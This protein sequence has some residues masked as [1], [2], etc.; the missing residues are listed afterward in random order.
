MRITTPMD[1]NS[2]RILSYNEIVTCTTDLLSDAFGI[3]Q[4]LNALLPDLKME[5]AEN[6]IADLLEKISHGTKVH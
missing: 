4:E 6:V 3:D 2:T 1:N 5:P